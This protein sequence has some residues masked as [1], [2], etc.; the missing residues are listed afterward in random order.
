L[1]LRRFS[2]SLIALSHC[3][4]VFRYVRSIAELEK[5]VRERDEEMR[6]RDLK[7]QVW[8]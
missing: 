7:Y 3:F 5:Q 8:F 1:A 6:Q 2:V 4:F